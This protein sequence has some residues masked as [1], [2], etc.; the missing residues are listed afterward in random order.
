MSADAAVLRERSR[1]FPSTPVFLFLWV[2]V[3]FVLGTLTLLGPVRWWAIF[4]R[5]FALPQRIEN[6]GVF[7]MIGML[8]MISGYTAR[9]ITNILE[10][11]GPLP[12]LVTV[13]AV[14][15]ICGSAVAAW[16]HPALMSGSMAEEQ[17]GGRFTF[18]PY[19]DE[20]RMRELKRQGY[21]IVSLLH[22]A[23]VPFEPKLLN[24]EKQLAEK[25]G[26]PLIHVPMLPWISGNAEALATIRQ[27]ASDPTRHFYV[28]CY[29]GQDRVRVVR[30]A[31]EQSGVA[32]PLESRKAAYSIRE[33]KTFER[34]RVYR[35]G[36]DVYVTG[37]P[38][39]DEFLRYV[40]S[41]EI[42]QVVALLDPNDPEERSA[43]DRERL[44]L[45]QHGVPF[46]FIPARKNR[47]DPRRI[48]DAV[49][50]VSRM[51]K[52][53]LVHAFLSP[54]SGGSPWA[55]GFMQTF[56]SH[57]ASLPPTLFIVPL[58]KGRARVVVAHVAMGPR[59][60]QRDF[61]ELARRGV[62]ECI[63][64]GRERV[65]GDARNAARAGMR[66][67]SATRDGL[68]AAVRS[69]GPYYVYGSDA[70]AAR[71]ALERA[72]HKPAPLD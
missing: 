62:A 12:R 28:H 39:D 57:R 4:C 41:G 18:G 72:Y 63:H 42:H 32:V 24:D 37:Y 7:L 26:I 69:G 27:L 38:T 65:H 58:R 47:F 56:F 16:M 9:I 51:P 52:P 33:R 31:L 53:A 15:A 20:F 29:L 6:S 59:P 23:V 34:G 21:T 1:S 44:L 49:R 25:V 2:P 5:Y 46:E 50:H 3:G 40:L 64:V 61:R 22:P 54:S 55:D 66:W 35:L 11:S 30:R 70:A 36:S 67:R 60:A 48:R 10:S 13:G 43:I 8:F 68:V 45:K 71:A 19:P 14:L 17:H